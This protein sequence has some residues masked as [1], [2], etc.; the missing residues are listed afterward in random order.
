METTPRV[1]R[2][3]TAHPDRPVESQM[4]TTTL[5]YSYEFPTATAEHV[6]QQGVLEEYNQAEAPFLDHQEFQ[7][8]SLD[9]QGDQGGRAQMRYKVNTNL[10][11]WAKKVLPA[12]NTI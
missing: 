10:P 8:L 9:D 6:F 1:G 4:A 11:N 3:R 2:D 5:K 12:R 7:L